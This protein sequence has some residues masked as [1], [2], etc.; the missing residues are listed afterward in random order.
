MERDEIA[1]RIEAFVRKRF[2]V[3]EQDASFTRKKNLWEHGYVDS[4]GLLELV[5][6]IERTFGVALP[7][8]ALFD[9]AFTHV[10][11]MA[12]IVSALPQ[13]TAIAPTSATQAGSAAAGA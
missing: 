11:G 8:E 12:G 6:F 4:V 7:D 5:G 13:K 10:D 2:H 1:A 9:P 3:S